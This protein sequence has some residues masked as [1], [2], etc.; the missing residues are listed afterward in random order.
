MKRE[1]PPI[2]IPDQKIIPGLKLIRHDLSGV[3]ITD[4]PS[5]PFRLDATFT[6]S[7]FMAVFMGPNGGTEEIRVRGMTCEVLEQFAET[8][9]LKNNPRLIT[10]NIT[11]PEAV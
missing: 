7:R 8:N 11:Q 10:M 9:G 4:D 3:D 1:T 6:P 5:F 2:P